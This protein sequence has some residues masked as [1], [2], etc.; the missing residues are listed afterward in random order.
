M[1]GVGRVPELPGRLGPDLVTFHQGRD[2]V[3]AH[4]VPSGEQLNVDPKAT[5]AALEF[6]VDRRDLDESRIPLRAGVSAPAA[7]PGVEPGGA[8]LQ[9]LA[10]PS[11][12]PAFAVLVDEGISHDES[13]AKEKAVDFFTMSRSRR[14]LVVLAQPGQLFL[15]SIATT[16]PREGSGALLVEGL[17]P[18]LQGVLVDAQVCGCQREGVSL[19]GKKFDGLGLELRGELSSDTCH[20]RVLSRSVDTTNSVSTDLGEVQKATT[21]VAARLEP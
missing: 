1:V 18:L 12:R 15:Q 17:L 7:R 4:R 5:V 14:R 6:A 3:A 16:V 8:D 11:H 10:H 20:R 13:L 21:Q 19:L 2:R 9:Q